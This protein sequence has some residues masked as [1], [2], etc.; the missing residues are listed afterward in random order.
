VEWNPFAVQAPSAARG[1]AQENSVD[2]MMIN[3]FSHIADQVK[4][5]QELFDEESRIM[6]S[7]LNVGYPL[8]EAD[9]GLTLMQTLVRQQRDH[10]LMGDRGGMRAMN[11][12][13]RRR[14][15]P[16]A[17]AF[18]LKL[19]SL[20]VIT[21]QQQEALLEKAMAMF[22]GRIELDQVKALVADMLFSGQDDS[23]SP[24][25]LPVKGNS[26]N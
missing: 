25:F 1:Q 26:W 2:E 3:L 5:R 18:P 10:F 7:L 9:A 24:G 11:S 17:F 15:T 20:G 23:S 19:A 6:Q 4:N 16:D 21:H 12:E 8:H 22:K 13:E 14:F